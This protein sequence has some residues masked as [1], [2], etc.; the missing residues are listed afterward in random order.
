MSSSYVLK[1]RRDGRFTFTLQTHDGKV[2]LI[3]LAYKDKDSALRATNAA[4]HLAYR[5]ENYELLRSDLGLVYFVLK[6]ARGEVIGQSREYIDADSS[7][8]GIS[9]AKM[10]PAVPGLRI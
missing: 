4:R 9:M 3:S 6:N 10:K 2:L 7:Q 8:Q 1:R 5:E